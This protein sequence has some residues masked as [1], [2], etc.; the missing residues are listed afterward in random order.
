[1]KKLFGS[2]VKPPCTVDVDL[3]PSGKATTGKS[4]IL[5][6]NPKDRFGNEGVEQ[7][8]LVFD[9]SDP[10]QGKVKLSV[11][12]PFD[13]LGITIELFGEIGRLFCNDVLYRRGEIYCLYVVWFGTSFP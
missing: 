10:I 6:N 9:Q 1:M 8:L 12:K 13:H 2:I 5:V 4:T 3:E 11:E 7:R